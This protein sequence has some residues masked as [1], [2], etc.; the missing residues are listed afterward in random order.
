MTA[1]ERFENSRAAEETGI[2]GNEYQGGRNR[3]QS[4]PVKKQYYR[5][6]PDQKTKKEY[7]QTGSAVYADNNYE[8]KKS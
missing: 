1:G 4:Q 6:N 5:Y 7:A 3:R 8:G 2:S